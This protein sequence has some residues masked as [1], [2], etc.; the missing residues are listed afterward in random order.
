LN[1][2]ILTLF[3]GIGFDPNIEFTQQNAA[4]GPSDYSH[5]LFPIFRRFRKRSQVKIETFDKALSTKRLFLQKTF[6][7]YGIYNTNKRGFKI[8]KFLF[9][10]KDYDFIESKIQ[11]IFGINLHD[12]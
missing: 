7:I 8:Y 9:S 2:M 1:T 10:A 4:T 6:G 5:R 12:E 3:L 11:Q